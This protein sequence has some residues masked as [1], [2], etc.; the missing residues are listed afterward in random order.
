MEKKPC[1]LKQPRTSRGRWRY[2]GKEQRIYI[3]VT[4]TEKARIAAM[5]DRA[6]MTVSD[7]MIQAAML[8]N[9]KFLRQYLEQISST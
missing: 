7:F 2:L 3:R 8:G 4:P 9:V 5:A 6:E 1:H